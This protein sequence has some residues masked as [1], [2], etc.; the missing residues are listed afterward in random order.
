MPG[1]YRLRT[2][3]HALRPRELAVTNLQ[4]ASAF[5][6]IVMPL[7]VSVVNQAHWKPQAKALVALLVSVLASFVTSWIAG[8]L[9]GKSFATSFLIVLGTTL[10]TY[11]VF[12]KPSGISDSVETATTIK[13]STPAAQP[14]A[15]AS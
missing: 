8:D 5:V 2:S 12:W 3:A 6:G 11:R 4:L 7:V 13:K 9:N 1:Y 15:A 10:T 14:S